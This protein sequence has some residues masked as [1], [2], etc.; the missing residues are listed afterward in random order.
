MLDYSRG[1]NVFALIKLDNFNLN[2]LGVFVVLASSKSGII[3]AP[4]DIS[5]ICL[6]YYRLFI[7]LISFTA[8]P[9]TTS[10]VPFIYQLNLMSLYLS[11][12]YCYYR[13]QHVHQ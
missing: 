2:K 6:I 12:L 5:V 3:A 13:A 4:A 7:F 9:G 10:F 1:V 8:L 11:L